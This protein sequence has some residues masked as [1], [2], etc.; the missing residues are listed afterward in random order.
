MGREGEE[1]EEERDEAVLLRQRGSEQL[2]F[3]CLSFSVSLRAGYLVA[4]RLD[5]GGNRIV[6]RMRKGRRTQGKE[7][8]S[9]AHPSL[10]SG[11]R[12]LSGQV[13]NLP[14]ATVMMV[15]SFLWATR[16]SLPAH[17]ALSSLGR[18]L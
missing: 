15:P 13:H 8:G 1:E 14:G 2:G 16:S 17:P 5:A 3:I 4:F 9:E 6:W 11:H 10:L 7:G 18:A 12:G